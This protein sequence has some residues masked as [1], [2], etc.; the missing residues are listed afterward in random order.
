MTKRHVVQPLMSY[1]DPD[2]K[3]RH[4]LSGEGRGRAPRSRGR[5]R[6]GERPR[7]GIHTEDQGGTEDEA[8]TQD[9]N[10]VAAG[11]NPFDLP[12]KGGH[13]PLTFR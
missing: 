9:L 10:L 2:G 8:S 11:V 1:R 12:G 4:A 13:D 5:L 7:A 3:M 6:Q